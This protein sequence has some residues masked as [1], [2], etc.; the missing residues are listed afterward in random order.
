[1]AR[2]I[3]RSLALPSGLQRYS[4]DD[5]PLTIGRSRTADIAV[6]DQQLSRVHA[7][8]RFSV[9]GRFEIVDLDSTNLTI[10]NSHDVESAELK[11]GDHILLGETELIVEVEYPA[12][13]IH[14]MTTRELPALQPRD[15]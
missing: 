1:M 4:D 12:D 9:A 14:E 5:L 3:L 7:E 10:V 8:F 13:D 6:N 2:L 11:T 15:T